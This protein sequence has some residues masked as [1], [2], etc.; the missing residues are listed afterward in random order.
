MNTNTS[1]VKGR[2]IVRSSQTSEVVQKKETLVKT[3]K[4]SKKESN[5][6]KYPTPDASNPLYIFYTTLLKQK[7]DSQ[8]ALKWCKEH[9]IVTKT[10]VENLTTEMKKIKL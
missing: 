7:P 5:G 1:I 6:Q 3:R 8:M 2:R 9:G 4:I 10:V